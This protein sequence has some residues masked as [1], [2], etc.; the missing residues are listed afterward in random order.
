MKVYNYVLDSNRTVRMHVVDSSDTIG[1][2]GQIVYKRFDNIKIVMT[3]GHIS[4]ISQIWFSKRCDSLAVGTL[5]NDRYSNQLIRKRKKKEWKEWNSRQSFRSGRRSSKY[6]F[7]YLATFNSSDN[8][9]TKLGRVLRKYFNIYTLHEFINTPVSL[10]ELKGQR[11]VGMKTVEL[12][13]KAYHHAKTLKS[14]VK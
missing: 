7:K 9:V 3:P 12:Y 13:Y 2:E 14:N 5:L 11:G 10:I 8:L 4:F 1:N 6:L